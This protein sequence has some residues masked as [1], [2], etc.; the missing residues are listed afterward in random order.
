MALPNLQ[1]EWFAKVSM[2]VVLNIEFSVWM[3]IRGIQK[4]SMLR[5]KGLDIFRSRDA[6]STNIKRW[7]SLALKIFPVFPTS[8]WVAYDPKDFL[9]GCDAVMQTLEGYWRNAMCGR[10]TLTKGV[11]NA[12][13]YQG[14]I[15]PVPCRRPLGSYNWSSLSADSQSGGK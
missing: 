7:C 3:F 6:T 8:H 13:T 12:S 4:H 9:F 10:Y 11:S 15:Y 5:M 1:H 2:N 14:S